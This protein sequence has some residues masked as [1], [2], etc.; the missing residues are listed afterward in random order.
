MATLNSDSLMTSCYSSNRIE[1]SNSDMRTLD[2]WS[3]VVNSCPETCGNDYFFSSMPCYS[4]EN[5][6]FANCHSHARI[7]MKQQCV[8]LRY[9]RRYSNIHNNTC[10][11]YNCKFPI[12]CTHP[13]VGVFKRNISLESPAVFS[14]RCSF[15]E[16][17]ADQ[18]L[19]FMIG[20][21]VIVVFMLIVI[22]LCW[23]ENM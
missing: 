14:T 4:C 13:G 23:L 21:A 17:D 22:S 6:S 7:S 20:G 11:T 15:G 8:V 3:R 19:Y 10:S 9:K 1:Y 5:S 2:Q 18:I 12:P 16:E